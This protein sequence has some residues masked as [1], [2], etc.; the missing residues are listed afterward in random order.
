MLKRKFFISIIIILLYIFSLSYDSN[1]TILNSKKYIGT[2]SHNDS[3]AHLVIDKINVDNYIYEIGN[4]KNTVEKNI[5]LLNG[6]SLPNNND[7][8]SIFL[9]AHSGNSNISYFKDLDK[10]NKNDKIYF[11]YNNYKYTY[12]VYDIYEEV[13]DGNIEVKK[14]KY[15]TL[16]LTTCS[17][18]K[19][20]K[21]LI[22]NSCLYNKEKV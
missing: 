1:N 19:N 2:N 3:I 13:K 7:N 8:S 21:Q 6:S 17:P 18:N 20:D 5:Q 15:N 22:V 16:T 10:I 11:Y 4:W 9:A 12:K 14:E